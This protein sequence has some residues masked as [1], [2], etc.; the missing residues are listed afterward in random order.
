MDVINIGYFAIGFLCLVGLLGLVFPGQL[1]K[2]NQSAAK[3]YKTSHSTM[4]K[5][6]FIESKIYRSH[7]AVGAVMLLLSLITLYL[8]L[9]VI[10][11]Q[12]ILQH[13]IESGESMSGWLLE[14]TL[15]MATLGGVIG[16][17]FG[18][19][20]LLRPS[21]LKPLEAWGNRWFHLPEEL[22]DKEMG[23]HLEAWVSKNT[24]LFGG[25]VLLCSLLMWFFVFGLD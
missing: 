5:V 16:V 9:F 15:V 19:V 10:G 25:L 4:D 6:H 14:M 11:D 18:V 23:Q 7:H 12:P 20:I 17:C 24:R 2:F 13:S 22:L 1:M 3:K 8:V 21:M